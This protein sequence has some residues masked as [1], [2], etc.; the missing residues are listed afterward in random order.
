MVFRGISRAVVRCASSLQL[1]FRLD[2]GL[3]QANLRLVVD[4]LAGALAIGVVATTPVAA[5]EKPSSVG[6]GIFTFTSGPAAAFGMPG[7][8]AADLMIE[9]INAQGGI[10]GVPV[11]ATYVDEGQGTQGVIAEYRRLAGDAK[12][13]VLIAALSSANCLALAPLAEQL[14][15]PTVAWNCDTHQLLID[16]K[17]K[18]MFRPNGNTVPEFVAYALYVLERKPNMKTVAII[19]PDYAFGHDAAK[20]FTAALKALKPDVEIVAE[21]YPKLGSPNYQTEISRLTT[22]RPDVVFSNL[23][24]AD[25]ENFVRQA[26]PRG[27]FTSSQVIL[28]VGETVL[29][30][31]PLPDGVIVGVLGDGWWMSP[32]AKANP[33]AIKFAEAYKSRFG[34]YPVS[35]SI[36]MANTLVYMKDAYKAAML[37]N[38]GRWPTRAELASAMQGSK[39]ATLTGTVQTRA[40]NDGLVDQIVGVTMKT[41][42]Q[43]FPVIGDMVRYKGDS[44]MPQVGQDPLAWI[45]TL[46]PEFAKNLP[47]PGSY[48]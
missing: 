26:A 14:E 45:S 48:N 36:K 13:Q 6:L 34:E 9:Q 42:A 47:K 33:E 16:G 18:H 39:V 3:P 30:R 7:K 29:Q 8:N 22:A 1:L 44:V 40:D 28:A 27:L 10:A 23:W 38:G 19:N 20:I 31:V 37:K 35:P 41:P 32:D 43:P 11:S 2:G 5:Q 46:T 4:G 25:L 12:N 24:G 17:S 15:V 21:L